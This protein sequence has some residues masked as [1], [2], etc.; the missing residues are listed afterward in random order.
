M[1]ADTRVVPS[2]NHPMAVARQFV[3]ENYTGDGGHVLLGH[4]RN[5]FHCYA[6]THWREDDEGRVRSELWRWLE[7]ALYWKAG[8]KDEPPEL[9]PFEPNKYKIANVLE[10][11]KAIGASRGDR[12]APG[13]A[14]RRSGGTYQR[15]RDRP[16]S[17]GIL[18]FSTRE[19]LPHTPE[20]F[21]QHVLPF[22]FDPRASTPRRWLRFLQQLWGDDS[23][24]V[25]A[26]AE[27]F[28]YVVSS[29]TSLQKMFLIVGPK[30][31]GKGTI[32]RVLTGLLGAHN[33]AAPTLAGMTQNFGLQALIGRPL[34][35]I[36]DA[37]LGSRA[38]NMIA[39]ERLLSI[40]GRG[41]DHDRPQVPRTH[42]RAV[43][44]PGS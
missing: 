31:S 20:L 19:L 12:A 24:S 14:P 40:S 42:G 8:K 3:A 4:H 26:L 1:I 23:E 9:A 41:H 17:N 44:R 16:L 38:D 27:W 18:Q 32:A 13:L 43:S 37:R 39:V 2:P 7:T 28:G 33:T 11:L 29:D 21:E 5:T 35:V 30:R 22:E 36:S 15:G 34:A 25:A 6:G 10:A